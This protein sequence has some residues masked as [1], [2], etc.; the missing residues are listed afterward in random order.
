M[1]KKIF[2]DQF[3]LIW[4]CAFQRNMQVVANTLY[5]DIL[6]SKPIL[7]LRRMYLPSLMAL[8]RPGLPLLT[9]DKS[10]VDVIAL[11]STTET[12]MLIA[13]TPFTFAC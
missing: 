1:L 9:F 4:I 3:W 11:P 13:S 5:R 12:L 7:T 6:W 8:I 2:D 10:W